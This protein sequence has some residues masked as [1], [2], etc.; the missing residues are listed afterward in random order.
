MTIVMVVVTTAIIPTAINPLNHWQLVTF[1]KRAET[2]NP[3]GIDQ[4]GTMAN[5]HVII[6][7]L[8]QFLVNVT[9]AVDNS[10]KLD[11]ELPDQHNPVQHYRN[12]AQSAS[13]SL[14]SDKLRTVK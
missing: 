13:T 4:A 3:R 2:M 6:R 8:K 5:S 1:R 10:E 9:S 12:F 11:P 14:K 7:I